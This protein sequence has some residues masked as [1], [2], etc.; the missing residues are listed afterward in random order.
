MDA[1]VM[2]EVHRQRGTAA[3]SC[4]RLRPRQLAAHAGDAGADQ[5]LGAV[6][7]ETDADQDRGQ[8]HQPWPHRRLPDGRGR[9][10]LADVPGD[11]AADSRSA[12]DAEAR[13]GMRRPI[14]MRLNP[15]SPD[16]ALIMAT[17]TAIQI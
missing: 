5:G 16:D 14:V 13:A 15:H 12:A 17:R 1:I 2:A 7:P 10:P 6:E 3:A 11:F 4:A 9:H 8:G